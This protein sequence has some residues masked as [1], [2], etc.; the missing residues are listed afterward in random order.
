MDAL[1]AGI[2]TETQAESFRSQPVFRQGFLYGG[3]VPFDVFVRE[4]NRTQ[5]G[6]D[7]L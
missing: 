2:E 5:G 6:G 3:P 4:M 1:V 7:R